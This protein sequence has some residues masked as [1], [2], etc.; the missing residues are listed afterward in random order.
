MTDTTNKNQEFEAKMN[1]L[2][3]DNSARRRRQLRVEATHRAV[4]WL[5]SVAHADKMPGE[6]CSVTGRADARCSQCVQ[7]IC[8]YTVDEILS[9]ASVIINA[10]S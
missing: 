8:L 2:F 4:G 6:Y 10:I 1:L 9:D 7:P 5:S 3:S